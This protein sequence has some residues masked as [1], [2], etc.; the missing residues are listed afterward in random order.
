MVLVEEGGRIENNQ[1]G[2]WLVVLEG[3]EKNGGYCNIHKGINFDKSPWRLLACLAL[4]LRLRKRTAAAAAALRARGW[5]STASSSSNSENRIL[6]VK[7]NPNRW[8]YLC[9]CRRL[10]YFVVQGLLKWISPPSFSSLLAGCQPTTG[11]GGPVPR[12]CPPPLSPL[13]SFFF[14]TLIRT[15]KPT[16]RIFIA[17]S[18]TSPKSN[19]RVF[20]KL[21]FCQVIEHDDKRDGGSERRERDTK[22]ITTIRSPLARSLPGK[23][24]THLGF[25][26]HASDRKLRGLKLNEPPRKS[27]T[28]GEKRVVRR[29][30]KESVK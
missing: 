28:S 1:D 29:E 20:K 23:N 10:F 17:E 13:L 24:N 4:L 15:P 26:F 21:N 30:R 5:P 25:L 22:T 6:S 16:N 8:G 7:V 3:A 27:H 19:Q 9:I 18:D 12:S 14:F 2:E 11:G